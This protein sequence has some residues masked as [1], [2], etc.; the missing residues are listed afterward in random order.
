MHSQVKHKVKLQNKR[1]GHWLD[2]P[3]LTL[4][5]NNVSI[6]T[7]GTCGPPYSFGPAPLEFSILTPWGLADMQKDGYN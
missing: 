5:L 1:Q 7:L 3:G 2:A 4:I 6:L